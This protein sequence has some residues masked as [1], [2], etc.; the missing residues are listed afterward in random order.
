VPW[1][2]IGAII[3]PLGLISLFYTRK[4][5]GSQA[6]TLL[7]LLV[8][9]GSVGMTREIKGFWYED[10]APVKDVEFANALVKGLLRFA[11]FVGV[12]K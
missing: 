9:L 6:G 3:G 5:K 4:K 7:V 2:P 12:K 1:N 8:V 11:K 10:D